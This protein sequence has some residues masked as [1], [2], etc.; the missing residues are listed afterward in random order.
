MSDTPASRR[1]RSLVEAHAASGL[2]NREF[3]QQMGVNPRTLAWWRSELK[4][5]DSAVQLPARAR[6][7][8]EVTVAQPGAEPTIVLAFDDLK[9][10]VVV[11]PS[12]DLTLLRQLVVGLS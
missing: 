8:T 10:H 11:S 2:T 6:L 7:F 1:W 9:A 5:R 4:R 3:A 12:T